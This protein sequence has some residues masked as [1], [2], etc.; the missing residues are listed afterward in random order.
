MEPIPS[1]H[2]LKS[3]LTGFTEKCN[4]TYNRKKSGKLNVFDPTQSFRKK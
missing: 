1:K 2:I 4:M 3:E